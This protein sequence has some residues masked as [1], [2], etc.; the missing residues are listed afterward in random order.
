MKAFGTLSTRA[1]RTQPL[2]AGAYPVGRGETVLT[3]GVLD[4]PGAPDYITNLLPGLKLT[5]YRFNRMS[6]VSESR[7]DGVTD[8]RMLFDGKA[9]DLFIFGVTHPDGRTRYT[10]GVDL[11]PS[12]GSE[13]ISRTLG[14]GKLPLMHYDGRI[15][16]SKFAEREISYVLPHEFAYDVFL[17]RNLLLKL[18]RS[19]GRPEPKIEKPLVVPKEEHRI[20]P[21]S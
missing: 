7:P 20:E 15:V 21:R 18:I 12:L 8:N 1:T 11:L 4:G 17:R 3:D 14:Q 16:G 19:L 6:N 2:A 5:R 10:L 9:Y 13:A